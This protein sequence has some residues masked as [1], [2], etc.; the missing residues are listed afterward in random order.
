LATLDELESA[1]AERRMALG[2][3][4]VVEETSLYNNQDEDEEEYDDDDY[5]DDEDDETSKKIWEPTDAIQKIVII[6]SGP[7]GLASAVYAA[8]A[9]LKPVV[10]AP[11]FGG[12]LM[13]KG[14]DV[15]NFPGLMGKTGP[16]V[17]NLMLDQASS[18][19]TEFEEH[20][21]TSVDLT[22]TPK[23][24]V[25][26]V[27]TLFAHTVVIATGADSRWLGVPGEWEF[28]GGG[29][30][31][32]ATCDGFL[33]RD[34]PV[35]VIGGGDTA[36]EDALVLARTSSSVTLIHRR[37]SFSASYAMASRVLKHNKIN[38]LWN[39][40]VNEF[41][42]SPASGIEGEDGYEHQRLTGVSV[43][44]INSSERKIIN[45]AAAFVAIGHIPNTNLFTDQLDMGSDGYVHI[46]HGTSTS[47]DGVF[48]A[49]DVAD[50]VYRQ[51]ITSA[52]SGAMAALDAERW[53]ST[54]GLGDD[55]EDSETGD[56]AREE[57]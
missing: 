33:F 4:R 21:V 51:A 19:G 37:D 16:G 17:V 50:H 44:N 41:I 2:L 14:V 18:F 12:Q 28:R 5:D 43:S 30:S 25:T 56:S 24:I 39:T 54:R 1:V 27:S 8:R 20:M 49:G 46:K 29:V 23:R 13:G 45:C 22:S 3:P 38:I 35:V 32:C 6:G 40:T 26:N 15:E 52:G 57:L 9:G 34:K 36:M 53:L 10:V 47:L 31:T 42:G 7:A 48:A 55:E 11:P